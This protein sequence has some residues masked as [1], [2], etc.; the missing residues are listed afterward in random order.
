MKLRLVL[1]ISFFVVLLRSD[2]Q[3][4]SEIIELHKENMAELYKVRG[5]PPRWMVNGEVTEKDVNYALRSYYKATG[6]LFYIHHHD[7]L[8]IFFFKG[9]GRVKKVAIPIQMDEL[10][11]TIDQA[12]RAYAYNSYHRAPQ[13]R[14]VSVEHVDRT[15]AQKAFDECNAMLL[16][17]R[18]ELALL[19]HLVIVPTAN[20]ATLPFAAFHL[21][22]DAYLVDSMSM[23]IAP[24]IFEF[25]VAREINQKKRNH[26][27]RFGQRIGRD[28]NYTALFVGNPTFP[29]TETWDFPPLPG[30]AREL[31]SVTASLDTA[32]YDVLTMD[33]AVPS[34]VMESIE[35]YSLL[36]FATHGL[37]STTQ[38]MD[39]SFL[40]L[41]ND[42]TGA[43]LLSAREIMNQRFESILNARLVVLSACQTGLGRS[44]NGG[45]IG[46]SRAF[47]VAGAD[48]VLMSL[49]NVDD[50]ET[51]RLMTLFFKKLQTSNGRFIPH[52]A[53]QDAINTYRKNYSSDPNHWAAF[54]LFGVPY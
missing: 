45:V 13:R 22:E 38:P 52:D 9:T 27:K 29:S 44:L 28:P 10:E 14:G 19:D 37:T 54:S 47:Q 7:T 53:L 39:S 35:S 48:Q 12:S 21:S 25:M 23:S 43:Y 20:I 15:K 42:S 49:W 51:A 17:F 11:S 46:L 26:M 16:P 41:S 36:Y 3:D 24:S 18:Q 50:L 40:V 6:L 33:R 31:D 4:L 2:G 8:Q 5:A 30:T 34:R 1:L 32:F